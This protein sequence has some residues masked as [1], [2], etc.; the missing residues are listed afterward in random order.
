MTTVYPTSTIIEIFYNSTWN[1]ISSLVVSPIEGFQGISGTTPA[2]R[3]GSIGDC[4]MTLDNSGGLFTPSGTNVLT[5]E[6][7]RG[8]PIRVNIIFEGETKNVFWGR[9]DDMKLDTSAW[10]ERN[11]S[12]RAL[13]YMDIITNFT[14][15]AQTVD[16]DQRIDQAVQTI[17]DNL[18]ISPENTTLASGTY[19]FP[20][21]FDDV[22]DATRASSEF[23]KLALSET[24]FVYI[25]EDDTVVVEA[26]DDR[27]G[28]SSIGDF[29]LLEDGG[30]LVQEDGDKIL[31]ESSEEYAKKKG[32]KN[33]FSNIGVFL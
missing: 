25:R 3:I 26:R 15:K 10:G 29:L 8:I 6:W 16:T 33:I 13:D 7:V 14:M 22:K 27:T 30:F 4:S 32:F 20:T 5:T 24:G 19:T 11:V 21:V 31:L 17:L 9:V 18:P 2:D 12:I 28:L 23:S 1:D